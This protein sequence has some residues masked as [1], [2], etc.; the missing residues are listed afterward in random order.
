MGRR[1]NSIAASRNCGSLPSWEEAEGKRS[2]I[3]F[4]ANSNASLAIWVRSLPGLSCESI[5]FQ[6]SWLVFSSLAYMF[7]GRQQFAALAE[8]LVHL[9]AVVAE[10]RE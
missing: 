7:Q 6:A 3:S 4:R 9:P 2:S 10:V 1:R 5:S 8:L